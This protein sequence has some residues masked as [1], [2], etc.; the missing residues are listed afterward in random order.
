MS[1]R[2]WLLTKPIKS[3]LLYNII[4]EGLIRG[5]Q[6]SIQDYYDGEK[7]RLLLNYIFK[8]SKHPKCKD[9]FDF[10]ALLQKRCNTGGI[11]PWYEAI[12]ID[13]TQKQLIANKYCYLYYLA[14]YSPEKVRNSYGYAMLMYE[15]KLSE[16]SPTNSNI[17]FPNYTFLR[18]MIGSASFWD[19]IKGYWYYLFTKK[20]P[21]QVFR[22][23]HFK[24][25]VPKK[26][27][28]IFIQYN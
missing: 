19:I 22:D 16:D 9:P 2:S 5:L 14:G 25:K 24:D 18:C 10:L 7:S 4:S 28:K 17:E 21:I 12:T 23:V 13:Q 1:L 6:S 3:N 15:P 26:F 27:S 11:V 20:A 8:H